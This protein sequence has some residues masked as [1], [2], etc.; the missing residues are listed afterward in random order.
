MKL[1]TIG[2]LL[3][4]LGFGFAQPYRCDWQV[5][6]TGG[7][8]LQGGNLICGSTVGQTAVGLLSDA[9]LRAWIGFWQA[10][11]QVG[12]TE[13]RGSEVSG[14]RLVTRLEPV[15]PNPL[16]LQARISYTLAQ[17]ARVKLEVV[18]ISGRLV[19]TLVNSTEKP[20]RYNL[21]WQGRDNFNR[22]V[23]AGVYFLRFSA[24]SYRST[25][26]LI[27]QR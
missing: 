11:Y 13:E 19:K 5:A 21:I 16:R 24:D 3:I 9:N 12:I 25:V 14:A 1:S 4:F 26:K 15:Y 2:L 20:G 22:T 27:L 6:A 17:P 18:D 7:W 23:P 8:V 10:D